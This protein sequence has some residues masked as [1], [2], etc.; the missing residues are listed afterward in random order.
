MEIQFNFKNFEPSEQLKDYARNRFDKL[1]KYLKRDD[2]AYLQVNLEVD[3]FRQIA[4]LIMNADDLHLSAQ[5][6]SEDMYSTIDQVLD[7]MEAQ[8]R[9]LKGKQKDRRKGKLNKPSSGP[10][11]AA[12]EPMAAATPEVEPNVVETDVFEPKPMDVEEAAI[13]LEKSEYGF[14]VFFNAENNRV[15]VVYRRKNGDY[16]L[17]DPRM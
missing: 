10:E 9:K 5:H 17:I 8:L 3:R 11:T 7:K 4:E 15:N 12:P 2:S 16:G 1:S 14:L 6:E 13:Q